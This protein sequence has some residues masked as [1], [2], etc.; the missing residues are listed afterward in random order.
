[1]ESKVL[2][3]LRYAVQPFVYDI[4]VDWGK[5]TPHLKGISPTEF[6]PLFGGHLQHIFAMIK[7][8]S[9]QDLNRLLQEEENETLLVVRWKMAPHSG[10]HEG[11]I[12]LSKKVHPDPTGSVIEKLAVRSRIKQLQ[13]YINAEEASGFFSI[14]HNSSPAITEIIE[15]STKYISLN[16]LNLIY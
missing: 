14:P 1:M 5:L 12:P 6:P 16:Y 3:L 9:Q 2:R 4:E 15:L 7:P 13:S 8:E 10:S 11:T